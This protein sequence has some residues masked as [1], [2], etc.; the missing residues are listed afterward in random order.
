MSGF[1]V[2]LGDHGNDAA[3]MDDDQVDVGFRDLWLTKMKK[4]KTAYVEA[5]AWPLAPSLHLR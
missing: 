4:R 3:S 1:V 2:N 5:E